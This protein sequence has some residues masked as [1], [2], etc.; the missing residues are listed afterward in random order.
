MKKIIGL[1]F[2]FI[3]T[4]NAFSQCNDS[5]SLPTFPNF[6]SVISV[7][8]DEYENITVYPF[9]SCDSE[10]DILWVQ[11]TILGNCPSE[12]TYIRQWRVF[13]DWG[14]S[15]MEQQVIYIY[16]N[17]P[18]VISGVP[19]D[20]TL[21][22]GDPLFVFPST[23]TITD[24]CSS[25]MTSNFSSFM[26]CSDSTTSLVFS[27]E[28]TDECGNSS[29]DEFVVSIVNPNI[30]C[31]EDQDDEEEDDDDSDDNEDDEEEDDDDSDQ[32]D[33]EGNNSVAICHYSPGR[34]CQTLYVSPN[35]VQAHLNHGD[36][37]GPCVGPCGNNVVRLRNM[38]PN[39]DFEI[40]SIEQPNG[41]NK[42]FIK[43]KEN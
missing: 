5:L 30:I 7:S 3:F 14:N 10:L 31:D 36:Y 6:E 26:T 28:A 42:T 4:I 12:V 33:N 29:S 24:N 13:D 9:D 40:N 37:L 38:V 18:P 16:D 21:T 20:I 25:I 34:G 11:D 35:A 1:F 32:D 27:W 43:I 22:C 41:E 2:A 39:T 8:C 15:V 19:D 23:P 17:T